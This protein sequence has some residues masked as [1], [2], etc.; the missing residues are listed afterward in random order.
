MAM[1]SFMTAQKLK[2]SQESEKLVKVSISRS[3]KVCTVMKF[4]IAMTNNE[5]KVFNKKN[6]F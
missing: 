5:K 3:K 4:S 6:L 2:I 1:L